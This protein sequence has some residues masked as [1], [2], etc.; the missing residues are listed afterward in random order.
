MNQAPPASKKLHMLYVLSA[1][2][3]SELRDTLVDRSVWVPHPDY[4]DNIGFTHK[5]DLAEVAWSFDCVLATLSAIEDASWTEQCCGRVPPAL[6]AHLQQGAS[7]SSS[8]WLHQHTL[9]NVRRVHERVLEAASLHH[10]PA[11]GFQPVSEHLMY[12][13][14]SEAMLGIYTFMQESTSW[15]NGLHH[16]ELLD[17]LECLDVSRQ[18]MEALYENTRQAADGPVPGLLSDLESLV[19]DESL[20]HCRED[21]VGVIRRPFYAVV[22]VLARELGWNPATVAA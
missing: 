15:D 4:G 5:D 12:A 8:D 1:E 16:C 17:V 21:A 13:L 2:A 10:S 14:C 3:M 18:L 19:T 11:G 9:D 22:N 6:L 20:E 7:R